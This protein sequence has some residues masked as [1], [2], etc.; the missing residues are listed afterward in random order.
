MTLIIAPCGPKWSVRRLG[1][2]KA[3]RILP[4][5]AEAVAFAC[6]RGEQ[7]NVHEKNG[8]LTVRIPPERQGG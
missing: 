8:L 1:A 2:A 7:I 6:G 3:W 5:Q 4:T